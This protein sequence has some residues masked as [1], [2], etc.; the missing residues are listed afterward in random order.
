MALGANRQYW[1]DDV[2]DTSST[3]KYP[4]GTV[5][6]VEDATYGVKRFRYV[7][8]VNAVT[9]VVGH[10]VTRVDTASTVW[11]VTNDIT[12]GATG[13]GSVYAPA[14]VLVSAPSQNYYC[15]I[16]ENG[17]VATVVGDGS[18]AV[19]NLIVPH[20]SSDGVADAATYAGSP[21]VSSNPE[22]VL[23]R[24]LSADTGTPPVFAAILT[25]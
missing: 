1:D 21:S 16:Q 20:A 5:R 12:G 25:L 9:A 17:Y 7:K 3:A 14:G 11:N 24:A 18:V 6:E 22:S 4:L 15:W 13:N 19:G 8:F 23:G 10:V 2:T